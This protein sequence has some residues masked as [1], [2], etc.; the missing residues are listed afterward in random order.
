MAYSEFCRKSE[1]LRELRN[2]GLLPTVEI[3]YRAENCFE[4]SEKEQFYISKYRITLL[5]G[6]KLSKYPT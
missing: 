2:E 3:I 4:A 1:W 6:K 5:N